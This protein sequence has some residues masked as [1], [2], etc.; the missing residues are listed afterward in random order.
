MDRL[1]KLLNEYAHTYADHYDDTWNEIVCEFYAHTDQC[2]LYIEDWV[3]DSLVDDVV[4]SKRYWFIKWLIEHRKIDMHEFYKKVNENPYQY[5][6]E[7]ASMNSYYWVL[8]SL[9]TQDNPINF[10]VSI[11]K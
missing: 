8:S 4:I 6:N 7:I 5:F 10:L 2:F 1:I 3:Y 11:L 9:A